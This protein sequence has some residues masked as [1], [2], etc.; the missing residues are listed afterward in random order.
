MF[1]SSRGLFLAGQRLLAVLVVG[2]ASLLYFFVPWA[3]PTAR[4]DAEAPE[5]PTTSQAVALNGHTFTLPAGFTVELV[6]GPPLVDRPVSPRSTRR[7]GCTSRTRPGPTKAREAATKKA[8]PHRPAGRH[9]GRRQVRQG[10]GLRHNVLF[11]QGAHVA[12]R[13]ALRGRPAAHLE[14]HRHRRRRHRRQAEEWFDGKTLTGCANDLHGPFPGPDGWIYWTK[15]AFA[16][17][18]T[19]AWPAAGS[20][21]TR[22]AHVFRAGRTARGLEPVMT[23]GMDNPVGVAFTPGGEPIFTHH[24]PPAPGRRQAGRPHPRRLRRRLRQGPRRPFTSTR[25][26]RRT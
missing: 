14:V 4:T 13:L 8:A 18:G 26:R 3:T 1:L 2:L 25:G 16:R 6:A 10:D 7:A 23:G 11:P 19:Y 22:A 12:R 20:S 24:L 15:G 21:T 5:Q 9:Q 17:A